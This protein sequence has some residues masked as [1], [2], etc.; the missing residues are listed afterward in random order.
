M[1]ASHIGI[2]LAAGHGRR[3]G[4]TKQL[5]MW[6]SAAGHQPLVAAA[7]DAIS[8]VCSDMIVV[9][10]H[11]A[12][13]VKTALGNRSFRCVYSDPDAPMF[14]SILAGLQAAQQRDS[15]ATVVIQPGDHPEVRD[16][17][18]VHLAKQS[19]AQPER[20]IIPEFGGRGGH[21]VFIPAA[22]IQHVLR[23]EC[24]EGLG[25]FWRSHSELC[26]RES[27][28]DATVTRDIDTPAD[29]HD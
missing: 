13:A 12:E 19:Q 25:E 17:T 5:V 23:A 26:M 9:V 27:V 29:F 24:A 3:M 11:E 4:G 14:A 15:S 2:I 10:G 7:Y 18:L 16:A 1:S 8:S 21:P 20:A 22:I 6:R 28:D